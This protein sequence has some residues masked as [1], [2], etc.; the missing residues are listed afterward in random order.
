VE[1]NLKY[2]KKWAV[3]NKIFESISGS[4][5]FPLQLQSTIEKDSTVK[6]YIYI[7]R[8]PCSPIFLIASKK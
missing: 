5:P 3:F 7:R 4:S 8:F 2:L 6:I 1:Y